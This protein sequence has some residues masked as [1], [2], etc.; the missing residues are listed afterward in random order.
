MSLQLLH[1]SFNECYEYLHVTENASK[2]E[3]EQS[4]KKLL[5]EIINNN[6]PTESLLKLNSVYSKV[7]EKFTTQQN[8]N[9]PKM[10]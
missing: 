3:V 9:K 10:Q 5:F 4:Y 7:I 8:G 1:L 6:E 2:E